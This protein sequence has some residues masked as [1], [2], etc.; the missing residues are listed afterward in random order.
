M[1]PCQPAPAAIWSQA[2]CMG[3]RQVCQLAPLQC[4][5]EP[6]K[7]SSPTPVYTDPTGRRKFCRPKGACSVSLLKLL[8]YSDCFYVHHR[9]GA[10]KLPRF[11]SICMKSMLAIADGM[12]Y[13]KTELGI[14]SQPSPLPCKPF[15]SVLIFFLVFFSFSSL[16]HLF[17]VPCTEWPHSL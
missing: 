7:A 1:R 4:G 16:S 12:H 11:L 9:Q 6:D 10:E 3:T 5:A 17:Q 2:V 14:V 13:N 15:C 8:S